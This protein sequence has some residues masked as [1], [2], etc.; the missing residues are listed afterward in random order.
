MKVEAYYR[1]LRTIVAVVTHFP[2]VLSR[3]TTIGLVEHDQLILQRFSMNVASLYSP[4]IE[5]M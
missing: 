1:W 2:I 4:L 5:R 3:L